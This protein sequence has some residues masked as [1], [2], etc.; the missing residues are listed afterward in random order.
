MRRISMLLGA[1]VVILTTVATV[2]AEPPLLQI[3]H[4][5]GIL[6]LAWS[7]DGKVLATGSHDGMI[8]FTQI[9]TGKINASWE[10]GFPVVGM[11]FAPDGKAVAIRQTGQIM[12][13]WDVATGKK[14][15]MGGFPNYKASLLAFTRDG[16]QVVAAAY[17]EFVHWNTKGGASGSMWNNPP[18]GGYAAVAADGSI[19]GWGDANGMIQ[20]QRTQPRQ[21]S[22]LH[23][24]PAQCMA[25][26]PDGKTLAVGAKDKTIGLW[27]LGKN[28]KT[29]TLT[30]LQSL[31]RQLSFSVD[32]TTVAALTWEA[33]QVRVWDVGR[34]RTR[35][36]LTNTRGTVIALELSPDGK[37]LATA[38]SDGKVLVWNVATREL[39][40]KGPLLQ[41][42]N[43]ELTALWLDL[44]NA[45]FTKA[46][47]AWRRLAACGD[48]GVPFLQER[49][50][51]ISV[52]SFD[53][54][55]IDQLI[56]LLDHEKY[57]V[58]A[59]ANKEL[60]AQGEL[61][62]TPLQKL[63]ADAPSEE[64]RTRAEKILKKV[65]EPT[66]T[67]ER[68]QVLEAI[69]LLETLRT[70]LAK[71]ALEEIARETL[72]A[73]FRQEALWALERLARPQEQK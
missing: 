41:L 12:S 3:E 7:A 65:K 32:G 66:L 6:C 62:I 15:A 10:T 20:M 34:Q 54:K 63:L 40:V 9:P 24:G 17:G 58:R 71:K 14:G 19:I 22:A 28:Q 25:F 13:L 8:R 50:K 45:D 72:I 1:V 70:P 38:S 42:S 44:A 27:D 48:K 35:R 61:I 5:Q 23:V 56:K 64:A 36:L 4:K 68:L 53:T 57:A 16:Q 29:I 30:G 21:F 11:A 59:M 37:Y 49:I 55:R 43:E 18:T 31:P 46:D 51:P 47:A 39:D 26:G 2:R 73:Q 67:P 60:L 33:N 69:E 52:P